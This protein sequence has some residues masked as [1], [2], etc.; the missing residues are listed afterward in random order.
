M[1]SPM[2]ASRVAAE[3][4][5]TAAFGDIGADYTLVGDLFANNIRILTVENRTN[6]ALLFSL[7]GVNDW[8][9]LNAGASTVLDLCSNRSDMGGALVLS[10]NTGIWVKQ[11]AV[12]TLGTVYVSSIY[13]QY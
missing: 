10:A 7:D 3:T 5:R 9:N 8:I 13:G 6:A 4:L 2:N 11:S 12:P 1:S